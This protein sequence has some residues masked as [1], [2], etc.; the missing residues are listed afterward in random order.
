MDR[1]EILL[2][3]IPELTKDEEASL[4]DQL[5]KFL[6]DHKGSV[7]SFDRWGKY[8]LSYPVRNNDYGVYFLM[9]FD[10]DND[11]DFLKELRNLF[12]IKFNDLVMR[13][14]VTRLEKDQPLEY[15]KPP[16]L[17]DVPKKHIGM[18][19]KGEMK[20]K[21]RFGRHSDGPRP[22]RTE[23]PAPAPAETPQQE[24]SKEEKP[25]VAPEALADKPQAPVITEEVV[26]KEKVEVAPEK[27]ADTEVA[28][29]KADKP[30]KE[31]STETVVEVTETKEASSFAKASADELGDRNK[32]K[33]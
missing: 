7:V 25:V 1:Y 24:V 26:I 12:Y 3:T 33:S 17:E 8:R 4:E 2:L 14:I 15:K 27:P 20:P 29:E 5:E 11:K 9:R 30:V 23:R 28:P 32:D 19:E 18:F 13:H 6:N 16:S 10:V 31:E 21:S 22:E